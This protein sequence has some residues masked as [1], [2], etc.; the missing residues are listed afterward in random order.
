ME[1]PPINNNM[2]CFE[3]LV[4]HIIN[5]LNTLINNNMRCFEIFAVQYLRQNHNDKQ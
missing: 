1:V 4:R 2:R 3:M 5:G